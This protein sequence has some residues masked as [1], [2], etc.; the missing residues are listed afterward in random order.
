MILSLRFA[1]TPFVL[2]GVFA[3]LVAAP[4]TATVHTLVATLNGVEETPANTSLGLGT[5]TVLLDD[6]ANTVTVTGT[7][8][9]LGTAATLCHIHGPAALGV[10]AGIMVGLTVTG[11]TSGTIGSGGSVT[12]AQVTQILS[13]AT[14]VNVH[15]TA[16]PNG[17]IR[18]QLLLE[19]TGTTSFCS[20]DGSISTSCPCVA[21]N[22]V[23]N[24]SAA[25]AHG[26]ANSFDLN[27]AFLKTMGSTSPDTV[28]FVADIGTN[29]GGFAVL[30]ASDTPNATGAASGD[31]ILCLGGTMVKFGAHNA[32]TE[33]APTGLWTYPSTVQTTPVS[34]ATTQA[35]ATTAS[36][37]LMYRNA[38][39][40][41]C[42]GDTF[43]VSS[44]VQIPWP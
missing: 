12:A 26:C 15:T 38:V 19:P 1:R 8:S 31:G 27:G 36:Y 41:F 5:A 4:A 25:A 39:A 16:F 24:P 42:S 23:P 33:G 22:T 21:P 10:P 34:V 40:S 13:G 32:G 2:G 18:G 43:N 17:E 20:G 6:V 14:Y 44:G 37:Q 29:Y 7:Y 11:G 30:I 28:V 35:P 9:A 3:T